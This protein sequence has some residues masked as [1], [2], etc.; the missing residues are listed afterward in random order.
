[1]LV[2]VA[3][4]ALAASSG[5]P[6]R[7]GGI[8]FNSR[9]RGNVDLYLRRANGKV[10]RLTRSA[11][12]EEYPSFSADGS[13]IAF[14]RR[15][16]VGTGDIYVMQA[17]G[18]GLRRITRGSGDETDPTW[19]PD[20]LHLAYTTVGDDDEI[21]AVGADGR[22]AVDLT[23]SLGSDLDPAWSPDGTKI[24][25]ASNR[26]DPTGEAYEIY[27]MDADGSNQVRLTHTP[28]DDGEPSWSPDGTR[29]AFVTGPGSRSDIAVMNADGS[30]L[31]TITRNGRSFEPAWS[32]D[33]TKIA[34]TSLVS[35]RGDLFVVR[36][37]GT[38]LRRLTR[39][40]FDDGAPDWQPLRQR[41][42]KLVRRTRVFGR[43]RAT[44][45]MFFASW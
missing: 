29:I 15:P 27:L 28:G 3:A 33:G 31:T 4:S 2:G 32:P 37:D 39:S 41:T 14:G 38:G 36:A 44:S 18:K 30:G 25:F 22:E 21:Y 11:A 16:R 17:N 13:L 35:N 5:F 9:R 42:V 26:D 45:S 43:I 23:N 19:A 20:G 1:V 24:A 34:F 40:R 8:V 12:T 6:G 10:V 7:N